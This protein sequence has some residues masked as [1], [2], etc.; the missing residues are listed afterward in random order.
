MSFCAVDTSAPS[1]ATEP[2]KA[3]NYVAPG[4]LSETP[5]ALTDDYCGVTPD[6]TPEPGVDVLLFI[7]MDDTII[8]QK[9]NART[10]NVKDANGTGASAVA[11]YIL[12]MNAA[13]EASSEPVRQ[14]LVLS[15]TSDTIP[16]TQGVITWGSEEGEYTFSPATDF[17][18]DVDVWTYTATDF[19]T[20][21]V[22]E[23]TASV[24]IRVIDQPVDVCRGLEWQGAWESGKDY[25][26][27]MTG[28]C[29]NR[30][31]V[32]LG[33]NSCLFVC[34]RSHTSDDSTKPDHSSFD[35]A[36]GWLDYWEKMVEDTG[37]GSIAF[38]EISFAE[39][40]YNG[41]FDW[42]K[43]AT[44]G[45]WAKA[46]LTGI[47]ISWAGQKILDMMTDDGAGTGEEDSR[48]N[49]SPSYNG[50][51]VAPSLRSVAHSLCLEAGI[52]NFDVSALSDTISCHFSLSQQTS[53]R[54]VLDNLSRAFQFDMVDSAGILKFI[55][56]N[57]TIVRTLTHEDMGFNSS[58]D[59][60]APVTMKRL[61]S[62]DLPRSVSLTYM[63]EDLD[64]NNFTQRSEIATFEAGNDINLQ[65]PFML[66]HADAKEAT[67]RLL[68]GAHLE[69]MQYTFK[70]S[71]KNAVDLEP[72]D[73]IQIP[74]GAVRIVQIEEIDEG[75]LEIH[76]V[77]AG[78]TGAPQPITDPTGAIIGYT[79][80]TYIG[81]GLN[82]QLPSEV[83]N[84][85]SVVSKAGVI[86]FDPPTQDSS[87]KLPR[88]YAAV[89]SFGVEGW[90]G[91]EIYISKDGG[92]SYNA[93]ASTNK[94]STIGIV[95][96]IVPAHDYYVFDNTTTIRVQLKAGTLVSKTDAAVLAGENLC[97]VGQECIAFGVATLVAP[98]TYDLTHLL[99]GRRGSE[100]AISSHEANELFVLLDG[101]PVEIEM[102]EADRSKQFLFK[103][104]TYGSD[105]TKVDAEAVQ[106]IGENTVP[107]APAQVKIADIGSD[108]K[109]TWKERPRFGG[110][111]LRDYVDGVHDEDFGGY[112]VMIYNGTT[113]VR[114]VIVYDPV[115]VYTLAMQIS[116][117]GAPQFSCKASVSQI[118]N[119]YGGS[120]PVT[121]NI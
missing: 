14:F 47:G 29:F 92:A 12:R 115:F 34:I 21:G 88:V 62:V 4:P 61:Q 114:Q 78:A 102:T 55:P 106:I 9:N 20:D 35:G 68:T 63:A 67:D 17:V 16:T 10:F 8:V 86:W 25:K 109:V 90:P 15:D 57:S 83:L 58:G 39:S 24:K 45:D 53:V 116:D 7:A 36:A 26:D 103:T 105:L 27:G 3:S 19:G 40:L 32:K 108:Y 100:W 85:P 1:V 49:G 37:V 121:V 54:T 84:T 101:A 18:G 51:Y 70:T 6:V 2:P 95:P 75:V 71:Y 96:A 41:I 74:E 81:T 11:D 82:P 113:A 42:M 98:N 93:I 48:Y 111:E 22:T 69:R 119:R 38:P 31:V 107:F 50:T 73:I 76:C 91:A 99:R 13:G 64:Y 59:V 66:T 28:T 87:D 79:A 30:D 97:M 60:V 112:A 44:I 80:S 33:D 117:F 118:S 94:P 56:R 72:S 77:D 46:I 89:H 52:A 23:D 104:V 110:G 43:N 120:R 5:P 65:V